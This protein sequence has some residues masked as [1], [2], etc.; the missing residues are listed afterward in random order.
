M[1]KI[2]IVLAAL[3]LAAC[4]RFS[5][6]TPYR[7]DVQQ[8]NV[9]TQD[10]VSKLKP[11]MTK[12]QVRYALGTPLITDVFHPERWDYVYLFEKHG[13]LTER[14]KIVVVFKGDALQRIEGDVVAAKPGEG[15]QPAGASDAPQAQ[16]KTEGGG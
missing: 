6:L 8:G 10:M 11:G 1:R 14:R 3:L 16:P 4:S 2:T 9:V 15:K 5:F 7:I 12:A 13:V